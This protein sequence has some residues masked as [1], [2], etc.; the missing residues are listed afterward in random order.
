MKAKKPSKRER[1]FVLSLEKIR[2][3]TPQQLEKA[4]GGHCHVTCGYDTEQIS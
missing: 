3:L 4:A 1:Q 2:E